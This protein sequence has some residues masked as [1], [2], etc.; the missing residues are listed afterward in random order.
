MPRFAGF[1]LG[2]W[3]I[4]LIYII[5]FLSLSLLVRTSGQ[6][7]LCQ[8]G[9][10]AVGAVAFSRLT[11]HAGVPWLPALLLSGLVVVPIGALLAIPAIRLS[12]LYL[13]LATFGFGLV[14]ADMFY[15]S[16]V[17]FTVTAK[18]GIYGALPPSQLAARGHA[19]PGFYY[20]VLAITAA[21]AVLSS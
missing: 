9:F 10:A 4:F 7:S 2:S 3:T 12:G 14:L 21:A 20:V 11:L 8:M 18:P 13:A 6:V 16:S 17:M 15:Q 5:L 1:H 19:D